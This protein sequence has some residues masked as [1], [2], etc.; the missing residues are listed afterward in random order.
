M[1]EVQ[2]PDVSSKLAELLR[3]PDDLSKLAGLK[4]EF[5]RKKVTIDAQ[6][7]QG[8]QEQLTI[9]QS[10]MTS[11]SDGQKLLT[12]YDMQCCC[13]YVRHSKAARCFVH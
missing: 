7:K 5:T 1:A 13:T 8:L 6:L 4:S 3:H 2:N 11:I 10:G 12:A 9:T